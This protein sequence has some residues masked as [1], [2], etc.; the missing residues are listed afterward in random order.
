MPWDVAHTGCLLPHC[1]LQGRGG[2]SFT[3]PGG[4]SGEGDCWVFNDPLCL[5]L[6]NS[7]FPHLLFVAT[8]NPMPPKCGEL[9]YYYASGE[10][11]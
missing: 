10:S 1:F 9:P 3:S 5:P 4:R 11:Y 7:L 6:T 8:Y 2:N